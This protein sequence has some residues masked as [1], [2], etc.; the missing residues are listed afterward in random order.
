MKNMEDK[1]ARMYIKDLTT[2][3][4]L[5]IKKAVLQLAGKSV[6]AKITI[7]EPEPPSLLEEEYSKVQNAAVSL[8]NWFEDG[9][10]DYLGDDATKPSHV[11]RDIK[12]LRRKG[13]RAHYL[14]VKYF[15]AVA[16]LEKALKNL[17]SKIP[18]RGKKK[19]ETNERQRRK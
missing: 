17:E 15:D 11:V 2:D 5:T 16:V 9:E 10:L 18:Q 1:N 7:D 14:L 19:G 6:S 13:E 3:Q 4:A 12:A 8:D